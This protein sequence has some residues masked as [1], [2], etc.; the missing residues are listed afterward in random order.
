MGIDPTLIEAKVD[1]SISDTEAESTATYLSENLK[2]KEE[3]NFDHKVPSDQESDIKPAQPTRMRMQ[4]TKMKTWFPGVRDDRSGGIFKQRGKTIASAHEEGPEHITIK[5]E[6]KE[7]D[8]KV[9]AGQDDLV[10]QD[11]RFSSRADLEDIIKG[12]PITLSVNANK[13]DD[14][15]DRVKRLRGIVG[16]L[17]QYF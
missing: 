4:K 13:S 5:K 14:L 1:G 12:I 6:R 15:K 8:M 2:I 9:F 11:E 16:R 3:T 10:S 7:A 17:Q